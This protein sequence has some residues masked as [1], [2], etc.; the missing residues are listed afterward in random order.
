MFT[1]TMGLG[2]SR[3]ARRIGLAAI[4]AWGSLAGPSEARQECAPETNLN[5]ESIPLAIP[6]EPASPD[7]CA[8]WSFV[9]GTNESPEWKTEAEFGEAPYSDQPFGSA[10][11]YNLVWPEG[12]PIDTPNFFLSRPLSHGQPMGI[13]FNICFLTAPS[14]GDFCHH[15]PCSSAARLRCS[16]RARAWNRRAGRASVVRRCTRVL[17]W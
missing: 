6:G 15:P 3:V 5:A 7:P 8:G 10:C 13:L 2:R 17:I 14:P 1:R 16:L 9:D 11:W 4:A 12:H